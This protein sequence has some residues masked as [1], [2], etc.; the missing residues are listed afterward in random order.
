[1]ATRETIET[2]EEKLEEFRLKWILNDIDF[3]VRNYIREQINEPNFCE[4]TDE[5]SQAIKTFGNYLYKR[6]KSIKEGETL[7]IREDL[8]NLLNNPLFW[9]DGSPAIIARIRKGF[10]KLNKKGQKND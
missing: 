5:D 9:R 6:I 4:W 10:E 3:W 8:D 1:M 7:Q 2:P